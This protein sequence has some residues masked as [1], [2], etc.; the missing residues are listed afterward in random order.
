[1]N[2]VS[3]KQLEVGK[4]NSIQK[5]YTPEEAKNMVLGMAHAEGD[6]HYMLQELGSDTLPKFLHGNEKE[7]KEAREVLNTRVLE[8]MRALEND[9]HVVLMESFNHEYRGLAKEFSTNLIKDYDCNTY[10]EKA[11]AEIITNAYIRIL[12]NSR[13]LNN[14]IGGPGL[15]IN[16]IKTRYIAM[17]SKQIDRASRQFI[18]ALTVLNQMKTPFIEVNIKAKTA[19]VSQ[20]QQ[21]NLTNNQDINQNEN[22][23]PK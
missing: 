15:P 10:A 6:L 18:T 20:N 1:M 4:G 8:I 19:F 3:Q 2:E 12:D 23:E 9:T 21:V 5:K 13:R 16:D 17:I 7:Q 22:V 14:D 11:L